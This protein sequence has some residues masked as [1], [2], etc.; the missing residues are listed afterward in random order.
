MVKEGQLCSQIAYISRLCTRFGLKSKTHI[1][2]VFFLT[3]PGKVQ[4]V[5]ESVP[6]D[7][8]DVHVLETID[9]V[10][11]SDCTKTCDEAMEQEDLGY[12]MYPGWKKP[13]PLDAGCKCSLLF[14]RFVVHAQFFSTSLN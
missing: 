2:I 11:K 10:E 5:I 4:H 7:V 8:Q 1:M 14:I 13:V 3:V 6:D 12:V 9:H